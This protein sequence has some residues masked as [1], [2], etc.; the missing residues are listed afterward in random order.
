MARIVIWIVGLACLSLTYA[1]SIYFKADSIEYDLKDR[2]NLVLK[3]E[4]ISWARV[5][6]SGRD[7][8]LEGNAPNQDSI[9]KATQTIMSVWGVRRVECKCQNQAPDKPN[10][11]NDGINIQS[12]ATQCQEKID[13]HLQQSPIEFTSG[14]SKISTLSNPF[15]KDLVNIINT[16]PASL[17]KIAGHTDNVG[18]SKRNITLSLSRAEA[19]LN[20]F[21][22]ANIPQSRLKAVGYGD[23]SPRDNNNTPGGR[24]RN[25]RIEIKITP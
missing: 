20:Y 17:I 5:A 15:L 22:A 10:T 9:D 2:A 14:S 19:V 1:A 6:I 23:S 24:K 12:L 18:N 3:T 13:L 7:A 16:C 25:R 8:I 11:D 4:N 21:K